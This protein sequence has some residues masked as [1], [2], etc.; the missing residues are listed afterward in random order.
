M[1]LKKTTQPY[2]FLVRWREGEISGMH[3]GFIE[4]V[5]ENGKIISH[6]VLEVQEISEATDFP[7]ATFLSDVQISTLVTN[8][9]LRSE[10]SNLRAEL[11][12]ATREKQDALESVK[13]LEEKL[14]LATKAASK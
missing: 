13:K 12:K 9:K 5:T 4:F 11:E 14:M 10:N 3:V 2:E 1:S 7:L 8:E 6:K